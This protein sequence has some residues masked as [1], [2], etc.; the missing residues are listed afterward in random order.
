MHKYT[1]DP[2]SPGGFPEMSLEKGMHTNNVVGVVTSGCGFMQDSSWY[3]AE[4]T[5][6]TSTGGRSGMRTWKLAMSRLLM[7]SSKK[8]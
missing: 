1:A 7:S 6:T 4:S 2:N 3:C 8:K 5:L